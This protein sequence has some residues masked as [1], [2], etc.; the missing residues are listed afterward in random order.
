MN[1]TLITQQR[2]AQLAETLTLLNARVRDA[3]AS[4][5]GKAV[6][7]AVRDLVVAVLTRSPPKPSQHE[8]QQQYEDRW[9]DDDDEW[10]HDHNHEPASSSPSSITHPSPEGWPAAVTLTAIVM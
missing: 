5:M 3:V 6:G 10:H 4:E 7:D 2:L 1:F 8:P 9:H